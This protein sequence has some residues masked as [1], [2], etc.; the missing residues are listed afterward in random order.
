MNRATHSERER[1]VADVIRHAPKSTVWH[2]TRLMHYASAYERLLL[3]EDVTPNAV[4][5]MKRIWAKTGSLCLSID[6]K[7]VFSMSSGLH[8]IFPDE[9]SIGVPT[10]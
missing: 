1:F 2:A 10:I 9:F 6:C 3:S 5:K 4:R 7:S 8:V